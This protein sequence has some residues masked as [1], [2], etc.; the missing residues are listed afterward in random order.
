M[1]VKILIVSSK[2]EQNMSC[3][4]HSYLFCIRFDFFTDKQNLLLLMVKEMCLFYE[5]FED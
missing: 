4:L 5:L 2:C 1:L 3:R